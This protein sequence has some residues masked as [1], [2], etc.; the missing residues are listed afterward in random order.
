MPKRSTIGEII[1]YPAKG[2][3]ETYSIPGTTTLG[4]LSS[5]YNFMVDING[6]KKKMPGAVRQ[7]DGELN[8]APVGN[9]RGLFDFWRTSGSLKTRRTVFVSSG[10]VFADFGDGH[11]FDVT[12]STVIAPT[13][14][15]SMETFFGLLVM[16]WD[17]NPSGVPQKFDQTGN[18]APLGGT[19]PNG[20]WL[21]TWF[22]RLWMAGNPAAPDR[23]YASAIND[24]EDWSVLSGA[25][26]IDIDQGDQDPVGI[27]SLFPSFYGRLMVAKRRSVYEVT[28]VGSTF[29]VQV[30]ISGLGCVSHNGAQS[31]DSDIIFPS[32]RGISSLAMTN[33]LGAI[34]SS[35]LST[36]IQDYYQQTVNFELAGNMRSLYVPEINAYL[37]AYTSK[38][39]T[40][41]D[42]LLGYNFALGEWYQWNENI[43]A[44]SYY[45]DANDSYKTKVL[46]GD[47]LGRL[48]ILDLNKRSR[49]VTWFGER[50]TMQFA[51][52]IIYP[53]PQKREV[54]F[55]KLSVY[56]KPSVEGSILNVS[57]RVNARFVEDLEIDMSPLETGALIG[58]AIIGVDRI[59]TS[60]RIKHETK[61]L[62]GVG[63]AIELIFTHTPISDD[64]D[65][66]LYGFVIEYEYSGESDLP[67]QQ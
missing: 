43:S 49:Q 29:G 47:D 4:R 67:K 12:G 64:D 24:P 61:N 9:A 37:L 27:T 48:G 21:R 44:M 63:E 23:L 2:G 65:C 45:V 54:T 20:R 3:L 46:V 6:A 7:D 52:G 13:D 26:I 35:F 39:S 5:G 22:N 8:M 25:E 62:H 31:T 28:P 16:A 55:R 15:V 41:N 30:L 51:T 11:Y 58:S 14:N 40:V 38:A 53:M 50:R 60:G 36:S 34:D 1:V 10:R 59:G 19:P 57:Y 17:T 32:E 18:I 33:K 42:T 56:F 66:E